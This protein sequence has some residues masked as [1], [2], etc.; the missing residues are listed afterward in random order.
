MKCSHKEIEEGPSEYITYIILK[1]IIFVGI[2]LAV[3][4]GVLNNYTSIPLSI[5]DG[6]SWNLYLLPLMIV[7]FFYLIYGILY[8]LG[9]VKVRFLIFK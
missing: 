9:K 4:F 6:L 2:P 1:N 3:I 5:E 7:G 8:D